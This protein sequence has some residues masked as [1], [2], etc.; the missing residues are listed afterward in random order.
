M[1][2]LSRRW[3]RLPGS[4]QRELPP[5][6]EGR[7]PEICFSSRYFRLIVANLCRSRPLNGRRREVSD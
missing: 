2:F 4:P 7:V 5:V 3:E 1:D 6:V